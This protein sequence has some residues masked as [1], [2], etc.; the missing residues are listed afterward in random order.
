M[1]P[2]VVSAL[3]PTGGPAAGGSEVAI[4][5]AGFAEASEVHFGS[6]SAS[7]AIVS[8]TLIVAHS[9]SGPPESFVDVTVTSPFGT[10]E[11]TAADRFAYFSNAGSSVLGPGSSVLGPGSGGL[12]AFR[13]SSD[14]SCK[15]GLLSRRLAVARHGRVLVRLRRSGSARCRGKLTLKVRGKASG[16][17]VSMHTIGA[18]RFSIAVSK[19]I[20]LKVKLNA[21]GRALLRA[22]HGKVR[23]SLVVLRLAPAPTRAQSASVRLQQR[24]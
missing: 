19:P 15:L 12:L 7:F 10:S 16:R 13:G 3:A 1:P 24:K 20:T 11:P 22:R 5:G 14:P 4:T 6:A 9:P 17:R 23:A 2:P 21:A 18:T 8:S